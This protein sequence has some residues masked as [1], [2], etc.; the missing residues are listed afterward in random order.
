MTSFLNH[1]QVKSLQWFTKPKPIWLLTSLTS[2]TNLSLL[3]THSAPA[4]LASLWILT[5]V[6]NSPASEPE[7][8]LLNTLPQ[9][10]ICM[11]LPHLLQVCALLTD[12]QGSLPDP[13][14]SNSTQPPPFTSYIPALFFS[15]VVL[16]I[17]WPTTYWFV[18]CLSSFHQNV[19]SMGAGI[20][21]TA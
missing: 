15:I 2:S 8:F 11:S 18:Y 12:I 9:T 20:L 4:N 6:R 17:K 1:N 5:Q 13:A 19:C 14:F 16:V 10:S 3:F 21:S 7:P